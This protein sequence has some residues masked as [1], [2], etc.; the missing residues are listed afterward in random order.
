MWD[1]DTF[2]KFGDG[3][4]GTLGTILGLITIILVYLTY[5]SQ[6]KEL[7][8]QKKELEE[9]RLEFKRTRSFDL[10]YRELKIIN[11]HFD[12]FSNEQLFNRYKEGSLNRKIDIIVTD[13][14]NIKYNLINKLDINSSIRIVNKSNCISILNLLNV[15]H[16]RLDTLE[17][18]VE[19]LFKNE[20]KIVIY[21]SFPFKFRDLVEIMSFCL[22]EELQFNEIEIRRITD[23]LGLNSIEVENLKIYLYKI[24]PYVNEF[25]R[26]SKRLKDSDF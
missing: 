15:I 8:N 3:I 2:S 7:A 10:V 11:E 9:Q 17:I 1:L 4:G 6:K 18:I 24:Y 12:D 25:D 21:N 23:L 5:K 20:I 14:E 19:P 26:L 22:D 13:F 16:D